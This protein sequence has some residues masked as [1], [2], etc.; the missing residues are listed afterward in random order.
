M[1]K[2][3]KLFYFFLY[4]SGVLTGLLLFL[5]YH[6]IQNKFSLNQNI[7]VKKIVKIDDKDW[8]NADLPNDLI[9]E[10]TNIEN[11][12][13]N[14]EKRFA[15]HLALRIILAKEQ[16]KNF[17][18]NYIPSLFDLVKFNQATEEDALNYYNKMMKEHGANV[19]AGQGFDKLKI[20]IQFQ[21]NYE[22]MNLISE[23]KISEL[24]SN[25][26]Y[27]TYINQP[28]GD[29]LLFDVSVFPKRGNMNTNISLISIIDFTNPKSI[30]LENKIEDIYKKYGGKI[31][32]INIPYTANL[33]SQSGYFAKGAFC[34]QEQGNDKYWDYSRK[35]LAQIAKNSSNENLKSDEIKKKV[36]SIA[37]NTKIEIKNFSTCLESRKINDTLI[38]VQNKLY[39]TNGF[40][41]SPTLYINKRELNFSMNELE[42]RIKNEIN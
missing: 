23:Q 15:D 29:P 35:V 39:S 5:A 7:L 32:F 4:V 31:N 22:K 8:T 40:K 41:G 6:F 1:K 17:D 28:L 3:I 25:K 33:D 16:K 27:T 10:Y 14:A 38:S 37:G 34:A 18:K 2:R 12:I 30:D 24:I 9:L 20:Q 36:I 26:K 21:L 42:S 13:Y 19:F 11:N